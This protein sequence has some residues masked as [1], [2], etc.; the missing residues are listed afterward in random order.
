MKEERRTHGRRHHEAVPH[1]G[2]GAGPVTSPRRTHSG[3][4]GSGWRPDSA[5]SGTMSGNETRSDGVLVV[6]HTP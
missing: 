3:S 2:S 4:T 5:R 6:D 1:D